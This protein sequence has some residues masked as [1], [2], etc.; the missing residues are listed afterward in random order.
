MMSRPPKTEFVPTEADGRRFTMLACYRDCVL[1]FDLKPAAEKALELIMSGSGKSEQYA[2]AVRLEPKIAAIILG[3]VNEL[4]LETEI[5][6]VA[7]AISLLGINRVRYAILA[8]S[9]QRSIAPHKN[10]VFAGFSES[11]RELTF[12]LKAYEFAKKIKHEY[13]GRAF[14]AGLYFDICR[15][16]RPFGSDTADDGP[17][18]SLVE[19]TFDRGMKC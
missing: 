16:L 15:K 14:A 18:I 17:H 9:L 6:D 13:P 1:P 8:L 2:D 7:H 3:A 10:P 19:G 11:E 12:A 4:G 5:T